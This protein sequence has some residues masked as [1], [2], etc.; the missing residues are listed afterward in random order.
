MLVT[1]HICTSE[2]YTHFSMYAICATLL[3][4]NFISISAVPQGKNFGSKNLL[5]CNQLPSNILP[6]F[7][8]V[9]H[10]TS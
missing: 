5:K 2:H 6:V 4:E 9:K 3:L 10:V 7:I 1:R 8:W